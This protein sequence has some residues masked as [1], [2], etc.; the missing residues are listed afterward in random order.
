MMERAK[1]A[2]PGR[3]APSRKRETSRGAPREKSARAATSAV[4]YAIALVAARSLP[5]KR[6]REKIAQRYDADET[7]NAIVRM[8]ELRLVDDVAWAERFVRDRFERSDK[9]RHRIRNELVRLGIAAASIDAAIERVVDPDSERDKA[10]RVLE[11]M[12]ARTGR[13]RHEQDDA[14]G[15]GDVDD[16]T[17]D[18]SA[19]REAEMAKNRLFRRMLARGYPAGLV[20]DLLDVS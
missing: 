4:E 13:D 12:Q 3:A 14:G 6:L 20:R 1:A 16:A 18:R 19:S 15:C 8:R 2:R 5:E 11:R 7:E 17:A 9:G 10:A